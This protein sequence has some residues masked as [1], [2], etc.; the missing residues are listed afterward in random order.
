[1]WGFFE[2]FIYVDVEKFVAEFIFFKE[3]IINF[4]VYIDTSGSSYYSM[5]QAPC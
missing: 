4:L 5:I 2:W 1:M 3:R